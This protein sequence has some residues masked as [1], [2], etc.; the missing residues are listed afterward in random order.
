[1]RLQLSIMRLRRLGVLSIMLKIVTEF[2][3]AYNVNIVKCKIHH[4]TKKGRAVVAHPRFL[5][6]G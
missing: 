4:T 6:T 2:Q 3:W 1:M 5:R